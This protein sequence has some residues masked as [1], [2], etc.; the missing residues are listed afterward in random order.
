[1][2]TPAT[3]N[4]FERFLQSATGKKLLDEVQKESTETLDADRKAHGDAIAD[5]ARERASKLSTLNTAQDKAFAALKSLRQKLTDVERAYDESVRAR[6]SFLGANERAINV[7][8]HALR[9][10]VD[11]RVTETADKIRALED[12]LRVNGYNTETEPR[13][14]RFR[15]V[16]FLT[17]TNFEA[18][19]E[20]FA[21]CRAAL[22]ALDELA[23]TYLAP[24][25]VEAALTKIVATIPNGLDP[26]TPMRKVPEPRQ[27]EA[28]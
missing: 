17:A 14:D 3:L 12:A 8:R 16:R 24:A 5:L 22:G 15:E 20:R 18:V 4:M 27:V 13:Y 25:D 19:Q 10:T 7:H 28:A 9:S 6:A 21:A 23:H 2:T 11:P 26:V 1:M